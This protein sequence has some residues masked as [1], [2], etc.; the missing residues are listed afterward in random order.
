VPHLA[1][2]RLTVGALAALLAALTPAAHAQVG[3]QIP[4][5]NPFVG[6][7]GA[8]GEVYAYGLRNPF[9]WS[10]DRLTGDMYVGDVGAGR[11]E[12]ITFVP[13]SQGAGANFGWP[14][15]EGNDPGPQTCT[16]PNYKPP[17]HTYEPTSQP[18]VGGYVARHASLGAYQGRYLFGRFSGAPHEL[19]VMDAG[20]GAVSGTGLQVTGLTSFGEDGVGRLYVTGMGNY[21]ARLAYANGQLTAEQVAGDFGQPSSVAAP[22]G[23]PDRL[24]IA[25][26]GGGLYL[27]TGGQNHLFID[28]NPIVS[29]GGESGLLSVAVAPDYA[30]SGRA[31]VFYTDNAGNLALDE[32]RRSASNPNQA[33]PASRRNVL[34]IEHQP[35]GNHNGGQLLFGP[36]GYLYLSTGDGGGDNDLNGDAQSLGSL[37]GK[38][39]RIDPDPAPGTPAQPPVTLRVDRRAPRLRVRVPRRQRV[40]KQRGAIAYAGCDE[41]C[42]IAAAAVLRIGKRRLRMIGVR[43]PARAAQQQGRR[44]RL[45]VK[46]KRR[47]VRVLRR[48]LRRGRRPTVRLRLRATDAAGNRSRRIRRTVRVRHRRMREE[49]K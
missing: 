11:W 43:R 15:W 42:T 17:Q 26:L 10:F 19:Y 45:K 46:L 36:D 6:T 13:R 27:R 14:C 7:A 29:T 32:L 20:G 18:V 40:L 37:L 1:A 8:R 44:V 35:A 2:A 9:R 5:D 12:E 21:V 24:F 41:R 38:I 25:E 39:I 48:A 34:T 3:Y 33:D 23:D 4:P 16:A 49:Q 28:L 30:T 22:F 31:F 47:H